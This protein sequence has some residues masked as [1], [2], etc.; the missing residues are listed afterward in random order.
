MTVYFIFLFIL[1]L[2]ALNT[3]KNGNK[4]FTLC[5]C[6]AVWFIIGFRALTVG[7]DTPGYYASFLKTSSESYE[8]LT[9]NLKGAAEPGFTI[10][11]WLISKIGNSSLFYLSFWAL[12]PAFALYVTF[13][14]EKNSPIDNAVAIVTLFILTLWAFFVAGIRQTCTIS[15]V[16][17]SSGLFLQSFQKK[18]WKDRKFMIFIIIVLLSYS[19]HNS[20]LLFLILFLISYPFRNK[21]LSIIHLIM[22]IATVTLSSFVHASEIAEISAIFFND[23]FESYG[24]RT[25]S[26]GYTI[27]L[28]AIQFIL[29]LLCYLKRKVLEQN[30]ITNNWLLI[31]VFIGLLAQ[32]FAGIIPDMTRISYYFSIFYVILLPRTLNI[33]SNNGTNRTIYVMCFVFSF[34]YLF[35]LS[36]STYEYHFNF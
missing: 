33:W 16:L 18:F 31:Q 35:V 4:T 32:A 9:Y 19:I 24:T 6:L 23:R 3:N 15:I 5:T 30:D 14:R 1:V 29:F 12:F 13:R 28:F 22:A 26:E 27:V 2:F 10:I 17:M 11:N 21:R 8:S 36:H 7:A 20:V 25:L 34:L